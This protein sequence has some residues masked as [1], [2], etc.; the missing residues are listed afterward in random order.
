LLAGDDSVIVVNRE[1]TPP[2]YESSQHSLGL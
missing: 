2:S 1:I